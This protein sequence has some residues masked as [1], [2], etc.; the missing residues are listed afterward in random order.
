MSERRRLLMEFYSLGLWHAV[1]ICEG[2]YFGASPPGPRIIQRSTTASNDSAMITSAQ[3]NARKSLIV[4]IGGVP[5][6]LLRSAGNA[7]SNAPRNENM[8][9]SILRWPAK[10][11]YTSETTPTTSA[12]I[13]IMMKMEKKTAVDARWM[14]MSMTA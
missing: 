4:P 7:K 9:I 3:K 13:A 1:A 12:H 2:G 8:L 5:G 14:L 6:W 10:T 11:R